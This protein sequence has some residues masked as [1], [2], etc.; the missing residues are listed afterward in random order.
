MSTANARLSPQQI[1]QVQ[2]QAAQARALAQAQAQAQAAQATAINGVGSG[3]AHMSPPYVPR[4]ATS[5][6]AQTSPPNASSNAG[7]PPRPLSAQAHVAPP[8]VPGNALPRPQANL[9]PYFPM[10]SNM[11]GPPQYTTEQMEQALRLQ[12]LLQVCLSA[13]LQCVDQLNSLTGSATGGVVIINPRTFRILRHAFFIVVVTKRLTLSSLNKLFYRR[14]N[15]SIGADNVKK[16]DGKVFKMSSL[17]SCLDK[18][19]RPIR[20]I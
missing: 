20:R 1:M 10:V 6:P 2:A 14:H 17:S 13:Y 3:I 7:N 11:Q 15:C 5:S 18:W 4:A 9:G 16:N 12:N 8:Q 19:E